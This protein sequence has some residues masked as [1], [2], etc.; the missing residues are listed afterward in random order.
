MENLSKQQLI[1]L[2]LLVSFVTS[3]ATGIVTVALMDQAPPGVTQTINRVVEKTIEKVVQAPNQAAAVITKET[4]VIKT[5]DLVVGAVEK[6]SKSLVL[7]ESIGDGGARSVEGFGL[8]ISSK[9]IIVA[10]KQIISGTETYEGKFSD[11]V[12]LALDV[13]GDSGDL[14]VIFLMPKKDIGKDADPK[15]SFAI[16]VIGNSDA[17]KLGQAIVS[18]GGE[19]SIVVQSGIVS[20]LPHKTITKETDGK[21]EEVSVLTGIETDIKGYKTLGSILVNLSGEVVGFFTGGD[22]SYQYTPINDISRAWKEIE[23]KAQAT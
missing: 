7:I 11:G 19:R 23:T 8:T 13:I 6:N 20:S 21:K 4:I 14:G 5:D 9:G 1:L 2:A 10:S 15:K 3:I 18:I 16:S 17:L 12:T 22:N